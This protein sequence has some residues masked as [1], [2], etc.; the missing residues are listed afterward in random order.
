[1]TK[2]KQFEKHFQQS[3]ELR[4]AYWMKLGTPDSDVLSHLINPAFMGGPRWPSM[5]QAFKTVRRDTST[6]IASD[7]LSDPFDEP[8]TEEEAS[9][10]GFGLEMYIET[11][12]NIESVKDSWQFDLVYQISQFAA[13]NGNLQPML[14]QMKVLTS[15]LYDVR[16]PAEWKN[17]EERVGIIIGLTSKTNPTTAQLSLEEIDIVNVKLLTLKELEFVLENGAEGRNKLAELLMN[18][19]NPTYSSL[20]R[21]SVI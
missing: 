9:Y 8:G 7:G 19:E 12:E 1:M 20:D 4:D 21:I 6:I 17:E 16:V 2:E 14:R 11:P 15:E 18:E 13:Q 3:C 5:R 10:N